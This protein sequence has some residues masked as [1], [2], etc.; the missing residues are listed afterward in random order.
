MPSPP[1]T[2]AST[3]L[4]ALHVAV[5]NND[6]LEVRTLLSSKEHAVDARTTEG[7]TP[8][9]LASLYGRH[10]MFIYLLH[11]GASI[12]KRDFGGFACIDYAKHLD[13]VQPLLDKYKSVAHEQ[14]RLSGRKMIEDFLRPFSL[15]V[16]Q[17]HVEVNETPR[18]EAPVQNLERRVNFHRKVG[19]LE[20]VEVRRIA[21]A[22]W[23]F[24]LG[25]KTW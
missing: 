13:F 19:M 16:E 20:I 21:A 23:D 2:P 4:T 7:A 22:E 9:M 17:D 3:G 1:S 24:D 8:T 12:A 14:P 6:L 10:K 25:R 5:I 18:T 15:M 11:K